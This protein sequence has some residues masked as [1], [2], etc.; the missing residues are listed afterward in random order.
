MKAQLDPRALAAANYI[1]ANRCLS[2]G[3]II[4][5]WLCAVLLPRSAR[6]GWRD[7]VAHHILSEIISAHRLKDGR[8]F[9]RGPLYQVNR[10]D[11]AE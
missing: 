7:Y 4:P 6:R 9:F 2:E 1:N 8:V 5:F 10:E 11:W 3:P